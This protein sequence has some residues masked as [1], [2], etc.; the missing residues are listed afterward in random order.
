[1]KKQKE[2]S[3]KAWLI[4]H[5]L[6]KAEF[7]VTK[8]AVFTLLLGI[9]AMLSFYQADQASKFIVTGSL[10]LTTLVSLALCARLQF[11]KIP[12]IKAELKALNRKITT[13]SLNR[14]THH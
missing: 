10:V 6:R 5:K 12:P 7:L 8:F 13:A 1:M 2:L 9:F 3:K 14:V 4:E 11:V